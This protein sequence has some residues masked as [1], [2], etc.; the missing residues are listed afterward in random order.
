MS[1]D[2]YQIDE[3]FHD[4]IDEADFDHY[5]SD[6]LDLVLFH[7]KASG[8]LTRFPGCCGYAVYHDITLNTIPTVTKVIRE[9]LESNENDAV[10]FGSVICTVTY[11]KH[12]DSL[13]EHGWKVVNDHL[14]Y[15][16]GNQI[17]TLIYQ[18]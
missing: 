7:E 13:I 3:T 1:V 11:A 4:G 16:S 12:K 5:H 6:T 17:T 8:Q 10:G 14:N 15:G 9:I 2:V 18:L